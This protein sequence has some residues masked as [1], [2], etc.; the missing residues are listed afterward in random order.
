MKS[1]DHSPHAR[2]FAYA[3]LVSFAMVLQARSLFARTA[4]EELEG[5]LAAARQAA[6]LNARAATDESALLKSNSTH[7]VALLDAEIAAAKTELAQLQQDL[8]AASTRDDPAGIKTVRARLAARHAALDAA[9]DDKALWTKVGDEADRERDTWKKRAATVEL[10]LRLD[11]KVML[12]TPADIEDRGKRVDAATKEIDNQ[13][14]QIRK[15]ASRRLTAAVELA[16]TAARLKVLARANATGDTEDLR[17]ARRDEAR[18]LERLSGTQGQWFRLN[19]QLEDRSRRNLAFARTDYLVSL[20]Y[21][22]ALGQKAGLQQADKAAIAAEAAET[23]LAELR[24]ALAPLQQRAAAASADA[25]HQADAALKAIGGTRTARDQDEARAAYAAAQ[26]RKNRADAEN[27]DWKEYGALEKAGAAFARE[28]ADRASDLAGDQGIRELTQDARLLRESLDTSEQYIRS[29]QQLVDKTGDLIESTRRDLGLDTASVATA[30]QSITELFGDFDATHP[31][32][33]DAVATR[34][35]SLADELPPVAATNRMEA[36]QR[37]EAEAVLV[38]RLAQRVMLRH[39]VAISEQW[40]A[41]SRANIQILERLAGMRLWRQHDP[42]LNATALTELGSLVGTVVTDAGFACDVWRLHQPPLPG[43]PSKKRLLQGLMAVLVIGLGTWLLGRRI[44]VSCRWSWCAARLVAR[45]PPL[46][47]AGAVAVALAHGNL[48]CLWLGWALLSFAAWRTLR[49]LMLMLTHDHRP[50]AG[51]TVG[52][53]LF[54]AINLAAAWGALLIPFYRIAGTGDNAW[55]VQAVIVRLWHLGVFVVLCRLA[56]HPSLMG[57]LLNRKSTSRGLRWLGA[58][59]ALACIAAAILA[60]LPY[61]AGL[62]NLGRTVLGT[63]EASFGILVVALF[64]TT[65]TGW[66][67]RRRA[68]AGAGHA[69]LIRLLQTG[70]V[71]IAGGAAVWLWA[72]LLNRVVLASNAPPPIQDAVHTV[73]AIAR[74]ILRLWHRELTPGMTVSSLARGL[75]VFVLSFW[76][77]GVVRRIFHARVLSRTPMDEATRLTFTTILG[78]LVILLGFVVALN[79]AGSSL[80]N[81]ALLAGAITVGLGF[82][83]QNII[84]NFVSSLLIHFGRTIRV[85]DYLDVGGTKGTVREIGL[86]NTVIVTDDGIT[87]LVPNGTFVSSNIINWTNPSRRTRLHVPLAVV[88]QADLALVTDLA[89]ATARNHSLVLKDPAPTVEVRSLTASQVNLDLL[90]WTEKPEQLARTVGELSLALDRVLREK[91]W[92]A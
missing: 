92:L 43:A 60:A 22:E 76:V 8:L 87:V 36:A 48:A 3:A 15:Y 23:R 21:A 32:A 71:L 59:A 12:A 26:I 16:D 44:P 1:S 73:A 82:G 17:N 19:K 39:R 45:I 29:L 9:E 35:Q 56:L 54:A 7:C 2:R 51:A 10:A 89:T 84:N 88:R 83:L 62:D 6:Q 31:P 49:T 34:L 79:V 80:Q 61:L 57:R 69:A 28:L 41:S 30:D 64:G 37:H 25:A 27:E 42:R 70:I 40:L 14:G 18:Q 5:A 50:P 33:P 46:A 81:L 38:A 75:L 11:M 52:G 58:G 55:D 91:G 77:S 63:V 66:A 78:Y 85:G 65:L 90:V 53:A 74:T 86:R 68:G 72:Q 67:I 20:R 13:I 47:V 4:D 24:T